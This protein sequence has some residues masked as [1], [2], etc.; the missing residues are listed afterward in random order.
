MGKLIGAGY[1]EA[2]AADARRR[3]ADF[4]HTH[5]AEPV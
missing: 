4:F 1:D 3:I 5:L 2:S